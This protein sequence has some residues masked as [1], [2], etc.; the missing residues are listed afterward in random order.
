MVLK[1]IAATRKLSDSRAFV[2]SL[3]VPSQPPGTKHYEACPRIDD[4]YCMSTCSG[5]ISASSLQVPTDF[6]RA[7]PSEPFLVWSC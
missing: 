4:S 6:E 5:Q 3:V 7:F 2:G 1:S